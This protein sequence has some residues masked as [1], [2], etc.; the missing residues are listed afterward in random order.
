[1][2]IEIHGD[3]ALRLYLVVLGQRPMV[4]DFITDIL[5]SQLWLRCETTTRAKKGAHY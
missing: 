5:W 4:D 1:M 2:K 3:Y